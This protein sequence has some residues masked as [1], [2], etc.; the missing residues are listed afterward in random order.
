[1]GTCEDAIQGSGLPS[2]KP[3]FT[4]WRA[5]GRIAVRYNNRRIEKP[6]GFEMYT[7]ATARLHQVIDLR[8][9]QTKVGEALDGVSEL[10]S[11]SLAGHCL[12]ERQRTLL[13]N[14]RSGLWK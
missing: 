11:V 8:S 12:E 5:S 4:D 3:G 14:K 13:N 7:L 2:K 10:L 9:R 6:A 1:M